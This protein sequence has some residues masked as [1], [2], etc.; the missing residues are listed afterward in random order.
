MEKACYLASYKSPDSEK[1]NWN[2]IIEETKLF[3]YMYRSFGGKE[4][5]Q[6][7]VKLK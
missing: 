7:I 6:G 4:Y 1:R 3:K 2:K 5:K